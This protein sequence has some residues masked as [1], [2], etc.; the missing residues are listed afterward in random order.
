ME[1][2]ILT[3]W[4]ELDMVIRLI[5]SAVLGGFIGYERER[6]EKPAGLRTHMLVSIGSCLF[7]ILSIYAFGDKSDPGRI[8][9]NIVVGIGF[10]GAGTIVHARGHVSGLTTA[11]SVWAVSAIGM[12]VGTGFYLIGIVAALLVF[13]VLRFLMGMENQDK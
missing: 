1:P 9:A 10:L 12:A 11:A 5:V 3:Q 7:T 6:R 8:A 2:R 4:L 13:I